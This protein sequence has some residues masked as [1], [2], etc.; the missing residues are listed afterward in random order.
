MTLRHVAANNGITA[1]RVGGSFVDD[2]GVNGGGKL[3]RGNNRE[4]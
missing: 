4:H 1:G 2:W 3:S